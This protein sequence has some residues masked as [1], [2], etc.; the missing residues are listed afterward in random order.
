M[1]LPKY[2]EFCSRVKTISGE[3]V[4]EKIPAMLAGMNAG[5]P[6]IMTD[7]GVV[8]AGLIDIVKK[9]MGSRMKIGAIYDGVPV[10]SD[11]KVV[12][13][14]AA[15]YRKKGCDS[16]ITVGGG[17]AI[18]T[19]KGVNILVSLGGD[20]LLHYEGAG[21]VRKKL[22]PHIVIPTTSGTGSETTLVAVVAIPER[23]VKMPF[24]SYFLLP[25]IA[26]LDPRMTKTL[27]PFLTALTGMDAMA[28]ACEAYYG[29][30]KNPISDAF[31]LSAIRN[32]SQNLVHVVK[33]PGD[34]AGRLALANAA[35][36]GGSSFSNSM[37]SMVHSLGH[38]IGGICH[39]PHGTCMSI[40]LPYGME[41]NLHKCGDV[42]GEMLFPLAGPEVFAATPKKQRA[43]KVIELIRKMNQDLYDATGGRHA[44][45]LKE[46]V[47]RNGAQ[48]VPQSALPAVAATT[49]GDGSKVYNPEELSY[50][51]AIMVLEH[52]YEG[53]PLDRKKI[54]K[55]GKKIKY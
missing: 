22:N 28:H 35:T 2:S 13:D 40:L 48:L 47:D 53:T 30:E 19:A 37:V 41:Y 10:D 16:L 49:M 29:L 33:N 38:S 32:I 42:I 7:K 20:N 5:K 21:S 54:K 52:A 31:S 15:V 11:Y 46:V 3:K 43:E 51:D 50:E 6:M 8:A 23:K 4:L 25:D 34:M 26:V 24:T 14:A 44:R 9:A 27:P 18:D 1:I 39:V 45:F 36:M 55:G 12:N 17:S